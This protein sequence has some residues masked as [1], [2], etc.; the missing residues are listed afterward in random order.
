MDARLSSGYRLWPSEVQQLREIVS[1][2]QPRRAFVVDR[3]P[4][5]RTD[6]EHHPGCDFFFSRGNGI[7][8]SCGLS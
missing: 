6:R 8:C 5:Q 2:P 1:G 4:V 7:D 3:V